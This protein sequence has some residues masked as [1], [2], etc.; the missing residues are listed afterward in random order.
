MKKKDELKINMKKFIL[1]MK[2]KENIKI[3]KIRMDNAGENLDFKA[4]AE[5]EF[6][7]IKFEMT[8]PGTPQQNGKVERKFATLFGY[9]TSMLN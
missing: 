9:A 5:L 8:S 7:W 3:T 6:P 2:H 4:M 1:M